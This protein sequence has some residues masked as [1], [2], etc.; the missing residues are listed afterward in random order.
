MK[1]KLKYEEGTFLDNDRKDHEI[2]ILRAENSNLKKPI[3][4]WIL[5]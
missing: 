4:N 2:L 1:E 3:V 5:A